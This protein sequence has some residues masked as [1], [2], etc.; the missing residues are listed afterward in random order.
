MDGGDEVGN[1]DSEV[2]RM[3]ACMI[4]GREATRKLGVPIH[5]LEGKLD[6]VPLCEDCFYGY[7]VKKTKQGLAFKKKKVVSRK[8]W[9]FLAFESVRVAK[10]VERLAEGLL[11]RLLAS[12]IITIL[13]VMGSALALILIVTPL[14]QYALNP[15]LLEAVR[16]FF[17]QH[18]LHGAL[19]I[20]GVDPMIPLVQGWLALIMTLTL[21]EISHA[22]VAV[23]LKAGEPRAVGVLLLGPI[24]VAGYVDLN[25][26]F[27]KSRSGLTVVAAG[28]GSNV[29]LSFF[30][31]IILSVY[32]L[33]RGLSIGLHVFFPAELLSAFGVTSPFNDLATSAVLLASYAQRPPDS[34][35]GR[36][37]HVRRGF[38]SLVRR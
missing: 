3:R 11:G 19:M 33:L 25:P 1:G 38:I 14:V 4:C 8:G 32:A 29:L 16:G 24:P 20:P 28:V 6:E 23:R 15:K 12:R 5:M 34:R 22:V 31:W 37:L 13:G 9:I 2:D 36:V 27:I 26:L 7:D 10:A 30:C 17:S 21:H 18:P 35:A